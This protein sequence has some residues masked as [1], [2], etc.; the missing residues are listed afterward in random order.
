MRNHKY[1]LL[2]SIA[3][4]VL[5]FALGPFRWIA[6]SGENDVPTSGAVTLAIWLGWLWIGMFAVA[7]VTVGKR[8]IWFLLQAPFVLYWPAM[9]IFVARA[10]SLTGCG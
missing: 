4:T 7:L 1:W 5:A 6:F 2:G 10:C 3:L 8:A 9:W